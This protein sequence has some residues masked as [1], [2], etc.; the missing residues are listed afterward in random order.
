MQLLHLSL[1]NYRAFARLDMEV[2]QHLHL[3]VGGNAQGKTSI[4]EVI[5][6]LATFTS[7]QAHQD[8]QLMNYLT[9]G[10]DPAV[11]R[12][13]ADIDRAGKQH[14]IEVRL[15]VE[16]NINGSG[17]FR[18]EILLDG[19]KKRVQDMLGIFNAVIF[20]PQMTRIIEDGPEERRRFLNLFISQAI[21]SYGVSLVAYSQI[22]TQRN[23]LLKQINERSGDVGQLDYWDEMLVQHGALIIH[24]RI[25]AI[26][27]LEQYS[28]RVHGELTRDHEVLGLDYRPA[29]DPPAR[30]TDQFCLPINA[31]SDRLEISLDE[32]R[33]GFKQRLKAV[34][35]EEIARGI[36]TLGPHRDEMRILANGI[37]LGVYGS[38]GQIRTALLSLKLGEVSWL[39]GMTGQY[40]VLLLDE[41]MAELDVQRRADLLKHIADYEQVFLTTTDIELFDRETLREYMIWEVKDGLIRVSDL[42]SR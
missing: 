32:I 33:Q 25:R 42:M 7:L 29:Y 3:I 24:E 4:L 31:Q 2:P 30:H 10:D 34:R 18:K 39:K 23:A 26:K 28:R 17:R 15:I 8:S 14:H 19:V 5:Y 11:S 35:G 41:I 37:D 12:I 1:T 20:L 36:T 16:K 38:R 27:E 9:L 40:P 22:L 21:P 13:V 6:Y